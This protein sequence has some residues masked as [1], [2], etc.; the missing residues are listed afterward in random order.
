MVPTAVR[1]RVMM[2]ENSNGQLD[3]SAQER[4][5]LWENAWNAIVRSPVVGN[6]Y[7]TFQLG[8]HIDNLSDTHNWYVKV[9]VETGAV[10]IIIVLFLL[11]QIV[12]LAFRIF[13][14]A[15]D[16][17]YQGLGLGLIAAMSSCLIANLFGDRWTYLEITGLLWVLIAAAARAHQLT[18]AA[19]DSAPPPLEAT[20]D[21]DP[22]S[23]YRQKYA[24]YL[25]GEA[26]SGARVMPN[27]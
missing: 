8:E 24:T 14:K 4:V 6:G 27:P 18:N 20:A 9:M 12:A 15:R 23:E 19:P 3:A 21:D 26:S 13:R 22:Y 10:G 11:E 16:P 1:E 7:A 17:L 25:L 5:S 2:T